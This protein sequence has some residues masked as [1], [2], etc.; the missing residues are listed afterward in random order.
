MMTLT[1]YERDI[2]RVLIRGARDAD[3]DDP[4]TALL[5]YGELAEL[6]PSDRV[7][8]S[9]PGLGQQWMTPI[10][11]A[12]YHI[13]AYEHQFGRPLIVALV[14]HKG[15]RLPG[16]GFA[17]L[18]SQIWP[19]KVED[20]EVFWDGQVRASV[21]YWTDDDPSRA[22]DAALTAVLRELSDVKSRLRSL[23]RRSR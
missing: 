14:V 13:G 2:R 7:G 21:D 19:T 17:K 12:L 9:K 10:R 8:N 16:A 15:D 23:E 22:S 5:P 11:I 6:V 20:N 4:F 18:V 3:R 1:A